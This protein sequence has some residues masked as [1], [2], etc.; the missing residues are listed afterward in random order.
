[1]KTT[2]G[3]MDI[4]SD[5]AISLD[6][7]SS[8]YNQPEGT[9]ISMLRLDKLHPV[10][11]GNKW[12][13]LRYNL[14]AALDSGDRQLITFGGAYSNHLI[15]AAAAAKLHG[16]AAIAVVRG[17]HGQQNLTPTLK[18]CLDYGMQ[19][20]FVSREEYDRKN[21]PDYQFRLLQQ[22]GPACIIPEGG[23]NE[24]GRRGTGD[25]AALIPDHITHVCL[26]VGTGTTF[27]GIR[28]VLPGTV[29]ITGF[30]A[31]KGGQYL[32]PEIRQHLS[33]D[34]DFNWR[35]EDRFHF[36]GFA[37]TTAPLLGFMQEFYNRTHIPLDI[38][39]TGKMMAGLQTLFNEGYFLPDA[40]ISCIHTGGLQ[41]NPEGMFAV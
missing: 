29:H 6:D 23:D 14:A 9:R 12:Y 30:T 40:R 4:I 5:A 38:V 26:P 35:L 21:E 2:C 39:Y 25:I 18:A 36:G 7:I 28:N 17:L 10:I 34:T 11:S 37:R 3:S 31:M 24:H 33:P 1:M 22:F 20:H 27:A 15:A 8:F 13:K 16:L 41:G 19:L 32:V